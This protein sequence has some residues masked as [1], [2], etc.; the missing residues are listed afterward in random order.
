MGFPIRAELTLIYEDGRIEKIPYD[1]VQGMRYGENWHQKASFLADLGAV[2]HSIAN[3]KQLHGKE[4]SF[5]NILDAQIA[6][7]AERELEQIGVAGI[8][9]QNPCCYATGSTLE[10]AFEMAWMSDEESAF[11]SVISVNRN[12]DLETAKRMD[13]RFVEVL[14]VPSIDG[15]ALNHLKSTKKDLRI[16]DLGGDL[17]KPPEYELKPVENGI[18][19]QERDNRLYLLDIDDLFKE[20]HEYEGKQVGVVTDAKPDISKK[21]LYD[22]TWKVTKHGK[23]NAIAIC[24]EYEDGYQLI[25]LGAGQPSRIRSVKIATKWLAQENLEKEYYRANVPKNERMIGDREMSPDKYVETLKQRKEILPKD[26]SYETYLESA[27]NYIKTIIN[28]CVLGSDSFFPFRDG[29]DYAGEFGI[30]DIIQP[31]GSKKDD[32]CVKACNE[33][34]IAM[35]FTGIRHFKH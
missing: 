6:L 27:N 13:G 25:G 10:Q 24:R 7:D 1:F 33:Y 2:S 11:G 14:I 34:K 35:V 32:E 16:L 31:G 8:K 28:R 4:L 26:S 17:G 22:F 3:A 5:N 12:F 9:H 23:S 21:G 20:Q 30:K 29:I 15:A 19:M 18:L